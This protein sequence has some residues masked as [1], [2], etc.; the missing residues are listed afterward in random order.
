VN[1]APPLISA[2]AGIRALAKIGYRKTRQRGSHA[3]L[4]CIGRA[5]LTV[6][7]HDEL[8][9]GTLRVTFKTAGLNVEDF[10]ALL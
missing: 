4:E 9:R 2:E 1:G 8:D 10:V 5:P 7:M 6:P 3:P